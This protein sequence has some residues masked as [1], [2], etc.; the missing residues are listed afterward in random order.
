MSKSKKSTLLLFLFLFLWAAAMIGLV[1][2][3]FADIQPAG[4]GK[5]GK[6]AVTAT[7]SLQSTQKTVS[8][9]CH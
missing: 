1:V 4:I 7:K 5:Q 8:E 9:N 6:S 3:G 2:I